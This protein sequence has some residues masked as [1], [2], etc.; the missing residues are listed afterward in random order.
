MDLSTT[1]LGLQLRTPL[2]PS[3]SPLSQEVDN[4][5]AMED[6]GASAVVLHSL[7]EE[8]TEPQLSP[9]PPAFRVDPSTYLNHI[10]EAKRCV[11]IPI[12]ASL[13]CT[14][15]G[16][17]ISYARQ[18]TEAGADALELNIYKI[19]T[20]LAVTGSTIEN[21]YI[22]I[23]RT[24]RAATSL[25]LAVKLS[26]YFSNFANMASCFD[27]LGV[28]GLVLFNRFYQPDIDLGKMAVDAH[29]TLSSPTDMRLPLRWIAI[30]YGKLRA[31]L[32]ASTGIFRGSDIVKMVL[33][34]ADVTML[35]S[36]LLRHGIEHIQ[37]L[38]N[39]VLELLRDLRCSSLADLKGK[40]SQ[41]DCADPSVFE[42]D[43]YVRALS[44]YEPL[45]LQRP[46][47]AR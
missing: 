44:S 30:L 22:H 2:V 39:E 38:E 31:S 10:A 1:Y 37:T 4:I 3:A 11:D 9:S 25:P 46:A 26:P 19:P 27:H 18:I 29:V 8:Q 13:N 6:A 20:R 42:R 32:A 36:V 41:Q 34:G 28:D 16:G 14:T 23:V 33:V 17:W 21:G 45:F 7:F 24:I 35:C 47:G 12:I 40:L 5:K 43:Q 15:L